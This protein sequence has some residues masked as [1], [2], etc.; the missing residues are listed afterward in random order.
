ML[1]RRF[2]AQWRQKNRRRESE[3]LGLRGLCLPS[4]ACLIGTYHAAV[5]AASLFQPLLLSILL[6]CGRIMCLSCVHNV[7]GVRTLR[8]CVP[9]SHHAAL[10]K[11]ARGEENKRG[12]PRVLPRFL[13]PHTYIEICVYTCTGPWNACRVGI[14]SMCEARHEMG[15]PTSSH[16]KHLHT[17]V[18]IVRALLHHT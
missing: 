4:N 16:H 18:S 6:T 9:M 1:Q 17:H 14:V 8:L 12:A 11:D 2:V 15:T 13:V 5:D 3:R 10:S 7:A